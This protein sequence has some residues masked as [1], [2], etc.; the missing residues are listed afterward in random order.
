M[1]NFGLPVHWS[2]LQSY[3]G[4]GT[5][6][7]QGGQDQRLQREIRLFGKYFRAG[8]Q[9]LRH[10]VWL[11][12]ERRFFAEIGLLYAETASVH[13]KLSVFSPKKGLHWIWSVFLP[14][15]RVLK[16]K[17]AQNK[18]LRGAKVVQGGP[19]CL[20][21]GRPPPPLPAPMQS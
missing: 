16:K 15:V 2:I 19:K 4:T 5:I 6:I 8:G 9:D 11:H 10:Q 18:S 17:L 7:G 3:S 20:Q 1:E 14:K 21:G 12:R 13:Q